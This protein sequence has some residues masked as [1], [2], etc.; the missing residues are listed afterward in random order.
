MADSH[1]GCCIQYGSDLFHQLIDL[2]LSKQYF[3]HKVKIKTHFLGFQRNSQELIDYK[4]LLN[5]HSVGFYSKKKIRGGSTDAAGSHH[6][7]YRQ[8]GGWLLHQLI[9]LKLSNQ[10]FNRKVK[11]EAL[12]NEMNFMT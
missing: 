5:F 3:D 12:N 1:L 6:G 10:Y 2:K 4:D 11:N 8:H 7:S 9:Y